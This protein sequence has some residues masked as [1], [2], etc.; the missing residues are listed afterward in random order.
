MLFSK[1]I[2]QKFRNAN[3][4][5]KTFLCILPTIRFFI[6]THGLTTFSERYRLIPWYIYL[7]EFSATILYFYYFSIA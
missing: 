7:S 1:A 4:Q 2:A 3:S 6:E 5:A